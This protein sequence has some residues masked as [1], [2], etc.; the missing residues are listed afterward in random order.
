MKGHLLQLVQQ[1]IPWATTMRPSRLFRECKLT[2]QNSERQ[3]KA[4]GQQNE[5]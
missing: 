1:G 4:N 5:G 3:W 2:G